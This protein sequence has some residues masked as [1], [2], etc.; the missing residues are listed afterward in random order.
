M[1]SVSIE[2]LFAITNI[3]ASELPPLVASLFQLLGKNQR[4]KPPAARYDRSVFLTG[5]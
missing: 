2:Q 4:D 3:E 1:E 5:L